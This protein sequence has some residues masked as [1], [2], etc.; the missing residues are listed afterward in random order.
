MMWLPLGPFYMRE[1]LVAPEG[2]ATE[3]EAA[4]A[5]VGIGAGGDDLARLD[6][7]RFLPQPSVQICDQRLTVSGPSI[8]CT[9]ATAGVAELIR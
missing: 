9:I 6:V 8:V 7:H 5:G 1:I 2:E 3:A 4:V